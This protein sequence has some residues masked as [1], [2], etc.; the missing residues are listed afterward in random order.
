MITC[1]RLAIFLFFFQFIIFPPP[2]CFEA[3]GLFLSV[4]TVITN[5]YI[6]SLFSAVS[7]MLSIHHRLFWFVTNCF[8][9]AILIFILPSPLIILHVV[10]SLNLQK[11][12]S[13][14]CL[15]PEGFLLC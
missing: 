7:I 14:K 12:D 11:H 4:P 9:F 2:C 3:A 15:L 13:I 8:V 5:S 6:L 10:L 1:L